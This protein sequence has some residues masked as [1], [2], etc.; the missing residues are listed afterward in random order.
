MEKSFV[1]FA[2]AAARITGRPWTFIVCL[3]LVVGWAMSGPLFG[4]GET[5]QL[6]INT[7][8]TIITFLMVFL[9]Q[10]AQNRDAAA[11]HA[12]LDELLFASRY[13]D[14]GFIGIERLT[15]HELEAILAEV[16]R[17]AVEIHD[18][19]PARPVRGEPSH[20]P[21]P[22]SANGTAP[23]APKGTDGQA[24]GDEPYSSR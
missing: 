23:S 24:V 18:G 8:T 22:P 2:S 10:S 7:T 1:Q 11:I 14:V 6:L 3:I 13:A 16:E 21:R 17:R 19:H 9:I 4:F 15:D 5:W 12:K 20:D